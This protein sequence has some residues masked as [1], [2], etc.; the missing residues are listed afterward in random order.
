ME[1][2]LSVM[3]NSI[4]VPDKGSKIKEWVDE[5]NKAPDAPEEKIGDTIQLYFYFF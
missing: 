3:K 2:N 4:K 5:Q 1:K